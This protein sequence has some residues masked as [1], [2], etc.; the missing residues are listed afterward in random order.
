MRTP[1]NSLL[2]LRK[3]PCFRPVA[4]SDRLVGA[5]LLAFIVIIEECAVGTDDPGAVVA[6]GLVAVLADLR[7]HPRLFLPDHVER[8]GARGLD[9]ELHSGVAVERR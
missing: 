2:C 4:L 8:V 6:I 9:V 3:L 7:A 1:D 5:A